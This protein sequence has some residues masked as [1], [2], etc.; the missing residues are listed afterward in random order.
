VIRIRPFL[1]IRPSAARVR[2]FSMAR[3]DHHSEPDRRLHAERTPRSLA[4][5]LERGTPLVQELLESRALIRHAEPA[6]FMHRQVHAGRTSVALVACVEGGVFGS[7]VVRPHRRA[8]ADR[9]ASWQRHTAHVGVHADPTIVGFDATPEILDLFEREMNDRPL[10]HVV[11]EDGATHTLWLG[12]RA[13]ALAR[14]FGEVREGLLLEGHHRAS[15]HA[16]CGDTLTMLVPMEHVAG[17]ASIACIGVDRSA[18]FLTASKAVR[19]ADMAGVAPAPG[20]ALVCAADPGGVA[21]FR[22]EMSERFEQAVL[23]VEAWAGGASWKAGARMHQDAIEAQVRA[24][25][26][27]C[28]ILVADPELSELRGLSAE[29]RLLPEASTWFE[30]RFRSGLCMAKLERAATTISR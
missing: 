21:W 3:L 16:A 18:A 27:G 20:C 10:F 6:M 15:P 29:G 8:H 2:E 25:A 7:Q 26:A 5:L 1:A 11:A 12:T 19:V 30:P 28:M 24:G 23:Q 9:A 4:A 17:R 22:C 13:E 14:A